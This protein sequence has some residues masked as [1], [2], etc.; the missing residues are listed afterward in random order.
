MHRYLSCCKVVEPQTWPH[1]ISR[2]NTRFACVWPDVRIFA[3]CADGVMVWT[4]R[5]SFSNS[6]RALGISHWIR[7]AS[8]ES[9]NRY[10]AHT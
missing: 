6:L 2:V 9:T 4:R 1:A 10:F 8:F 3:F 5:L 7:S